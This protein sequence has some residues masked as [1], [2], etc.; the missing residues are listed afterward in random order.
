MALVHFLR[1][2][3]GRKPQ[4]YLWNF[5]DIYHT[6]GDISTSGCVA[7]LLFCLSVT[8]EIIDFELAKL[9]IYTDHCYGFAYRS[10]ARAYLSSLCV[11]RVADVPPRQRLRSASFNQLVV[12]YRP[13]YDS[14]QSCH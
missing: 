10:S 13:N 1:A 8:V 5:E 14:E 9:L 12:A 7:I 2:H 4:V 11:T 3:N 6:F